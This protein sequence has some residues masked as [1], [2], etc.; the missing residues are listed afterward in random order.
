VSVRRHRCYA[1]DLRRDFFRW[2]ALLLDEQ[3]ARPL[4][5]IVDDLICDASLLTGWP[6]TSM[7]IVKKTKQKAAN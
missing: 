6:P 1:F 7:T 4:R 2:K 3:E 5:A